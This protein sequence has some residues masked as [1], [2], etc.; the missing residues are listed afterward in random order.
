[1]KAFYFFSWNLQY[2][3]EYKWHT[4]TFL[5][6]SWSEEE[7]VTFK[8]RDS[9]YP[10]FLPSWHSLFSNI[11]YWELHCLWNCIYCALFPLLILQVEN[12]LKALSWV[13]NKDHFGFY[14]FL[15]LSWITVHF[16]ILVSWRLTFKYFVCRQGRKYWSCQFSAERE[17]SFLNF[18]S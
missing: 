9:M 7:C 13:S 15:F 11:L 2:N 4:R 14:V 17:I 8:K 1:M 5:S 6:Y 12:S 3:D 16:Q 18:F 10:L